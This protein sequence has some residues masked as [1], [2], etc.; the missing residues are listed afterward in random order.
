MKEY[1]I[2]LTRNIGIG[3]DIVN[4]FNKRGYYVTFEDTDVFPKTIIVASNNPIEEL[5]SLMYVA[6]ATEGRVSN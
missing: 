6:N 3:K 4:Y 2:T 5:L 1:I